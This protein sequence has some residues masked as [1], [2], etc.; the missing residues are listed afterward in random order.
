MISPELLRRLHLFA[1]LDS[2]AFEDLAMMSEE[3]HFR[4]EA[5]LFYESDP[6]NA[7][8]F[9]LEGIVE[10]KIDLDE[11]GTRHT[12]LTRLVKGD[13]IGWSALAEPHIYTLGA[14]AVTPVEVIRLDA[15]KL[16]SYL[17][18][19]PTIGY[20]V[21]QRLAGQIG[22]RLTNLRIQFVSLTAP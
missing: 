2:E 19:H 16:R 18:D 21:M 12:D 15:V 17:D 22:E 6:A 4:H 10:L 20:R 14:C 13:L 8:Y 1:G 11:A 7:L 3:Q 5:W 9:I